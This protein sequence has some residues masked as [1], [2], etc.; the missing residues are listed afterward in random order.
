LIDANQVLELPHAFLLLFSL[1]GNRVSVPWLWDGS[2][3]K[4]FRLLNGKNSRIDLRLFEGRLTIIK[5][6]LW[7]VLQSEF[8][9][10]EHIID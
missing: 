5:A 7:K 4:L 6:G 1:L 8:I 10:V 2:L 9:A 3:P